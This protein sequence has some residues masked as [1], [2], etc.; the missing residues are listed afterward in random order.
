M[1]E[2]RL[3]DFV[4]R[5]AIDTAVVP[6]LVQLFNDALVEIGQGILNEAKPRDTK[7]VSTK[8]SV[9]TKKGN[10]PRWASKIA[11]AFA[12]E[13]EV[14]LDD[15]ADLEK[16]TKQHILDLLKTRLPVP[17]PT[18]KSKA[19]TPKSTA[20]TPKST[21]PTSS[22]RKVQCNGLTAKGEPCTRTGTV[23]PD[24]A[25][26]CYCF[27]HADQWRDFETTVSSDSD[28]DSDDEPPPKKNSDDDS[29]DEPPPKKN[30]DDELSEEPEL[31]E[32]E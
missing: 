15:F 25:K 20:S 26:N 5:H 27:R 3:T 18:P 11:E 24:S 13:K 2:Q 28:D 30:S 23:T 29:D 6:E 8:I 7:P 1:F 12:K 19:S 22:K 16:I 9:K 32:E 14:T 4:T 31:S 21:A 10:Q 17:N